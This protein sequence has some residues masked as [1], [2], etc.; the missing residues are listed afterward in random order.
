[1]GLALAA[2]ASEGEDRGPAGGVVDNRCITP[3]GESCDVPTC[4]DP[5][6]HNDPSWGE[7]CVVPAPGQCDDARGVTLTL[8]QL[9]ASVPAPGGFFKSNDAA[10]QKWIEARWQEQADFVLPAAVKAQLTAGGVKAWNYPDGWG[11]IR[12]DF[13]AG[14][15]ALPKGKTPESLLRALLDD[16]ITATGNDEFAGWVG[17]PV[18]GPGGRRVGDRIDLDIWGGDD[19]A[20][21]YWKIDSDRFCVITLQNSTAGTHPVSGIR[22]WGFVP[23][24]LNPNWLALKDN[25][26]YWGCA[27]PT[28]MVYTIGIDSPNTAGTGGVGSEL[29]AG[30]WNSLIRDLLRQN[31]RDGGRSGRWFL[32]RTVTQ[33]NALSPGSGVAVN[34][35]GELQSYYVSLPSDGQRA[36]E[37]CDTPATPAGGCSEAE[38]TCID[39]SCIVAEYRCDGIADCSDRD[40]E[41]GCETDAP[42]EPCAGQFACAAGSCIPP[43]WVCDGQYEDCPD[44]DDESDCGE[45]PTCTALE[46]ACDDGTCIDAAWQCDSI[47]DCSGGQDE[48][49]C[50]PPAPGEAPE[51]CDG[52]TCDDGACIDASWQCDGIVD[53]EGG[54]D[55]AC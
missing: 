39:G 27:G 35:P 55:E 3:T 2:C 1:L 17:W 40:D 43:E 42:A 29:Q 4:S 34:P 53:C 48:L 9:G 28:Y 36:G 14:V 23:I 5:C 32:Q 49:G 13:H 54:E 44:G 26:A 31:D 38:F 11:W 8:Q 16:P 30:T 19:G 50:P 47:D 12:T 41:D 37:V 52:F 24:S 21:G 15:L 18:A 46:F 10:L 22:C 20:I 45:V 25:Q 33:P 51:A 7:R 6:A